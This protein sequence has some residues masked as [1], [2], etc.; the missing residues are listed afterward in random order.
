M[1][2]TGGTSPSNS[3][4]STMVIGGTANVVTPSFP[5]VVWLNAYAQVEKASA[6]GTRPRYTTALAFSTWHAFEPHHSGKLGV[7]TFAVPPITIVSG[8]LVLGEVPPVLAIVGGALSLVGVAIARM[9]PRV[10]VC[11]W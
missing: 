3:Q 10:R 1:A 4:P 6:V 9:R 8:W 5:A 7:T 2:R 11:F